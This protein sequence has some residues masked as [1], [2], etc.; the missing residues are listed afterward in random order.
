MALGGGMEVTVRG[1]GPHGVA[2][3]AE[4][5]PDPGAHRVLTGH[6]PVL[7]LRPILDRSLFL[8]DPAPVTI[9]W[10]PA[11]CVGCDGCD[12]QYKEPE[13]GYSKHDAP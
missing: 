13:T 11:E 1:V 4:H 2:Q 5:G 3:V 9:C 10:G 7:A 8:L 6:G 12:S